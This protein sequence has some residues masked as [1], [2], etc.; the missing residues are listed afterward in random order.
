MDNKFNPLNF[1]DE[2][3]EAKDLDG[4]PFTLFESNETVRIVAPSNPLFEV[5]MQEHGFLFV[6]RTIKTKIYTKNDIPG[7]IRK[8][9]KVPVKREEINENEII[10]I[11]SEE[12]S[13]DRRFYID[14]YLSKESAI[15]LLTSFI[16]S[17]NYCLIARVRGEVAGFLCL[18]EKLEGEFFISLAAVKQKYRLSGAALSLYVAA[19]D[20]AVQLGSKVLIGRISS[21]NMAVLNIYSALG[22]RFE[23]PQDIFLKG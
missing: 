8:M 6:D 15:P 17:Q 13:Y 4:F 7:N 22:A 9:A 18:E 3:L 2:L 19:F 23:F 20:H 21:Q 10:K 12:F 11:A 16:H 5:K 14:K 1:K